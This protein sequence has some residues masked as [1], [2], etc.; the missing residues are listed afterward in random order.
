MVVGVPKTTTRSVPKPTP[1]AK[2]LLESNPLKD[3]EKAQTMLENRELLV[4]D[5]DISPMTLVN[6]I[7]QAALDVEKGTRKQYAVENLRCVATLLQALEAYHNTQLIIHA[8]TDQMK[9]FWQQVQGPYTEYLKGCMADATNNSVTKLEDTVTGY[10]HTL[11]QHT[12]S[13]TGLLGRVEKALAVGDERVDKAEVIEGGGV[14]RK[15]VERLEAKI[16]QLSATCANLERLTSTATNEPART[17]AS[18][19]TAPGKG[20]QPARQQEKT[21]ARNPVTDEEIIDKDYIQYTCDRQRQIQLEINGT[22]LNGLNSTDLT[23]RAKESLKLIQSEVEDCPPDLH[24]VNARILRSGRIMLE[25]NTVNSADWLKREGVMKSFTEHFCFG[26]RFRDTGYSILVENVPIEFEGGASASLRSI[27]RA[28]SLPIGEIIRIRWVKNPTKRHNDQSTAHAEADLRHPETA[29]NHIDNGIMIAGKVCQARKY[30]T[31]PMRCAKCQRFTTT[32]TAIT[33][34][35]ETD[36]CGTCAESHRTTACNVTEWAHYRCINC[37]ENGH[38]AWDR[39]CPHFLAKRMQME[40]LD[41]H[42]SFKYYPTTN[43]KTWAQIK[44]VS[45]EVKRKLVRTQSTATPMPT[46]YNPDNPFIPTRCPLNSANL[47][48]A[49]KP[50]TDTNSGRADKTEKMTGQKNT[51]CRQDLTLQE[52]T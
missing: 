40:K 36:T 10:E 44:G 16:D 31:E 33:C 15:E 27:E 32:H 6:I 7:L 12:E 3:I 22:Q 8:F 9:D 50:I 47:K 14:L 5:E 39:K 30:W 48:M 4:P 29:N 46:W 18:T 45:E 20:S 11:Q 21:G 34:T 41:P 23:K 37:K 52:P 1:T 13:L 51:N 43:P 38:A 2:E 49:A 25:V 26:A 35:S 17:Y 24:F 19:I 42:N 28:N